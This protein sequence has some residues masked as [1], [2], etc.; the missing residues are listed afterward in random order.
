VQRTVLGGLQSAGSNEPWQEL[1]EREQDV[2]RAIAKGQSNQEIADSLGIA[3]KTVKTHI[4]NIFV[5]LDVQDRTQA[6]I[7]AIRHGLD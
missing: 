6:A 4:S 1:T 7:Y 2:L 3:V 5:K